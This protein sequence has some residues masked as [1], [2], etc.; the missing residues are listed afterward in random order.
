MPSRTLVSVLSSSFLLLLLIP[1]PALAQQDSKSLS[2]RVVDQNGAAIRGAVVS[3]R[4]E[5]FTVEQ[6]TV[7]DEVGGFRFAFLPFGSYVLAIKHTGF[8]N[9]E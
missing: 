4:G 2:G 3:L 6:T 9:L 1:V 5:T 7:T 8:A